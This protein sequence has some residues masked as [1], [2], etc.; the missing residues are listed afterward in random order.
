VEYYRCHKLGHFQYECPTVNKEANYAE[1]SNEEEILLMSHV[2]LYDNNREGAWFLDSGCSNHMCGDKNMFC[3]LNEEF[4]QSLGR[5]K[6]SCSWMVCSTWSLM[7]S[8]YL[9]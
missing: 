3:E 6:S 4:R 1:L 9:N 7:Y 2:E 5:E 8:M